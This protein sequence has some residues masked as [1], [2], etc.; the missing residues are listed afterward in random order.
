MSNS[1][2]GQTHL[3]VNL[4]QG[5]PQLPLFNQN[6][7][8]NKPFYEYFINILEYCGNVSR[9]Y[10]S[11]QIGNKAIKTNPLTPASGTVY[12][13]VSGKVSDTACTARTWQNGSK[14]INL[15][16]EDSVTNISWV[17]V[18]GD[19]SQWNIVAGR[20]RSSFVYSLLVWWA[21]DSSRPN[22]LHEW[23]VPELRRPELYPQHL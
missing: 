21:L 9:S 10:K 15:A 18:L 5:L 14:A 6:S 4:N 20:R 8:W 17:G 1:S 3:D 19:R 22:S 11:R 7:L 13:E 23:R 16:A 12:I 2:P